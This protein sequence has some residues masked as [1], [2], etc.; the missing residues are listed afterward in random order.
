MA[1]YKDVINFIFFTEVHHK[2][3]NVKDTSLS[4]RYYLLED[5]IIPSY[6]MYAFSENEWWFHSCSLCSHR[7]NVHFANYRQVDLIMTCR[8]ICHMWVGESIGQG[9]ECNVTGVSLKQWNSRLLNHH[10]VTNG[11]YPN[12]EWNTASLLFFICALSMDYQPF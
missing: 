3:Q 7:D 12:N 1:S 10:C 8:S 11:S 4:Y 5:C 6:N 9:A 2:K